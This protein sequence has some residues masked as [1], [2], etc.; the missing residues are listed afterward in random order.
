MKIFF[1]IAGIFFF[2]ISYSQDRNLYSSDIDQYIQKKKEELLTELLSNPRFKINIVGCWLPP[3]DQTSLLLDF[4]WL[5]KKYIYS[6]GTV[7]TRNPDAHIEGAVT[8]HVTQ[9]DIK[10]LAQQRFRELQ[11]FLKG[12]K[13][14]YR[15]YFN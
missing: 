14:N 2:S 9:W 11:D 7:I 15:S 4:I 8:I 12:S 3:P 6:F 5:Q 13:S 10:P 1:F